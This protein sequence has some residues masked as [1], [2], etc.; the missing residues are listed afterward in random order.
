MKD[1]HELHFFPVR[2][3]VVIKGEKLN[4]IDVVHVVIGDWSYQVNN[5]LSAVSLAFKAVKVFQKDFS[6]I[7]KDPWQFIEKQAFEMPVDGL[8]SNVVT[9][10]ELFNTNVQNNALA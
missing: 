10:I 4:A 3:Y 8:S 5:V 2:P 1:L 7:A 6:L 9:F